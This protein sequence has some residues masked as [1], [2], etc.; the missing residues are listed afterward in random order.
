LPQ[1]HSIESGIDRW[2][3]NGQGIRV[4]QLQITPD[5][6]RPFGNTGLSV[7]PIVFGS[8]ALGN[9]FQ[10]IPD[11][12]KLEISSKWFDHVAPPVFIDTAGKYGAGMALEE[13]GRALAKFEIPPADVVISNKLGWKRSPLQTPEPLFEPDVWMGLAHDAV[14]RIS[15]EGILECWDEGCRLL[16]GDYKP[17]LASVH[18][19]DEYLAAASSPDDRRRRFDD[20]LD[21]Y[22]AL[23]ELK[24]R[25]EVAGVGVGAKDWRSIQEIDAAVPLD[26]VM[27]ANSFTIMRHP[28]EL[29]EFMRVLAARNIPI[30]NSAVFH[31]GFLVGGRFF[32]YRVVSPEN[33]ADRPLFAWRK[34]FVAL[35]EAHGVS[36]MHA[37]VQFGMRGPGVVAVA[38][39][40]SHADRVGDNVAAVLKSVPP[41]FWASLQEE[42]LIADIPANL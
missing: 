7:P 39:N 14:Q 22:R 16:G 18:D 34:S 41:Q 17:R 35:C 1:L 33:P 13:I 10:V 6:F 29:I 42:G 9:C 37:C 11:V 2:N 36:P 24:L 26:W 4:P 12:T 8:T 28:P 40:T 25:G 21:A 30:I 38:L 5:Q 3:R 20:I 31:A 23:G 32:D 15:Y 19:P 27:L